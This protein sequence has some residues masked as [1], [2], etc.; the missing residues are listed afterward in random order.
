MV[1][2]LSITCT[3]DSR[4][5]IISGT[6]VI[7]TQIFLLYL[8]ISGTL[9]ISYRFVVEKW[10]Q[11]LNYNVT[12]LICTPQPNRTWKYFHSSSCIYNLILQYITNPWISFLIEDNSCWALQK[13]CFILLLYIVCY[14]LLVG[15]SRHCKV[16][17][18]PVAINTSTVHWYKKGVKD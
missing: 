8:V 16:M 1:I 13:Y 14:T 9:Y 15:W 11:E 3:P 2:Y 6:Y 4:S 17:G 5:V 7:I 12:Q 18:F 10:L